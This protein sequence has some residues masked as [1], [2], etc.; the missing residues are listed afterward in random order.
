[1]TTVLTTVIRVPSARPNVS[2]S[3]ETA[4]GTHDRLIARTSELH[5]VDQ[6]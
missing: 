5:A 2:R 3:P 1:M 6:D 4:A